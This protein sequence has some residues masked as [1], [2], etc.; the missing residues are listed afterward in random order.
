MIVVLCCASRIRE[1][2]D[3]TAP[4]QFDSSSN[5]TSTV[6]TASTDANAITLSQV[7]QLLATYL[8]TSNNRLNASTTQLLYQLSPNTLTALIAMCKNATTLLSQIK[9]ALLSTDKTSN[10]TS[11]VDTAILN[12]VYDPTVQ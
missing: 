5:V 12:F 10:T 7:N 2:Y 4:L 9:N 3:A 11:L 8:N 6:K 1:G